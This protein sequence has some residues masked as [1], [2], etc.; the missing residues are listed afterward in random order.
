MHEDK[1]VLKFRISSLIK[2][3]VGITVLLALLS[4]G[5]NIYYYTFDNL[6]YIKSLFDLDTEGNISTRFASELLVIASVLF[7]I[8]YRT[9]R[10]LKDRFSLHWLFLSVIFILMALDESVMLHE[11]TSQ[12]LRGTIENLHFAWVILGTLFV[13]VFGLAYLKF[14]MNLEKR[15][16]ILFFSSAFIFLTGALLLEIVGNFYQASAGQDNLTYSMIANIEELFEFG[17]V[18]LLIYSLSSYLEQLNQY[19]LIEITSSEKED[20]LPV[21]IPGETV[22]QNSIAQTE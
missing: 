7:F 12:F 11:Q 5:M 1:S 10:K 19:F 14:F 16:K 8:V 18:I 6:G 22:T 2:A 9:K 13:I 17:G 20:S 3:L 21:I 15:W 4:V